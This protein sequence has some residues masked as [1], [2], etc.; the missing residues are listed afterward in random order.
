MGKSL[1][2]DIAW[3]SNLKGPDKF[4]AEMAKAV[5]DK[6][7][8]QLL[9]AGFKLCK[10]TTFHALVNKC[11]SLQAKK[12]ELELASNPPSP[13]KGGSVLG[14]VAQIPA[15]QDEAEAV[16]AD[17]KTTSNI[18]KKCF[19][20]RGKISVVEVPLNATNQ[21]IQNALKCNPALNNFNGK[22]GDSHRLWII[23]IGTLPGPEHDWRFAS[24][25]TSC[26]LQVVERLEAAFALMGEDDIV[27]IFDGLR[28]ENRDMVQPVLDKQENLQVKELF[29]HYTDSRFY[30][31][32]VG[33]RPDMETMWLVSKKEWRRV[34]RQ[35][36]YG[37]DVVLT[38]SLFYGD[39]EME[40]VQGLPSLSHDETKSILE[41]SA[42]TATNLT[43]NESDPSY[44]KLPNEVKGVLAL[45]YRVHKVE[46]IAKWLCDY[47][48]DSTVEMPVGN[49]ASLRAG[50]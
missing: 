33:G 17:A 4:W 1:S 26:R 37:N 46:Q 21:D 8:D 14:Q 43:V 16:S 39:Q 13:S 19:E 49:G 45:C 10:A 25:K 28:S 3:L 20:R 38:S 6:T 50:L 12:Q 2:S 31:C 44:P 42:C 7:L 47:R 35:K 22:W 30:D 34:K 48:F 41:L 40:D 29:L 27:S 5:F 23:N 9:K 18:R 36:R 15:T 11:E 24:S 32:G